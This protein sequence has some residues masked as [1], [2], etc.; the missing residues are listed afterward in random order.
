MPVTVIF[1]KVASFLETP[2]VSIQL[3]CCKNYYTPCYSNNTVNN[4]VFVKYLHFMCYNVH[5]CV[6]NVGANSLN[7]VSRTFPNFSLKSIFTPM[8]I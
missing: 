4:V 2:Q 1:A 8:V 6:C 3:L 5:V 7:V